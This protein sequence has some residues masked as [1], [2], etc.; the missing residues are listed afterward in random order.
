MLQ[1][2]RSRDGKAIPFVSDFIDF[3]IY[4]DA[5]PAVIENGTWPGS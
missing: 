4:I 3:S 2:A 1:P 5:E